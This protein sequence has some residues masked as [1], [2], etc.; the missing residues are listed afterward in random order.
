MY[1]IIPS[2]KSI[3]GVRYMNHI[4]YTMKSVFFYGLR[5]QHL[6]L[7]RFDSVVI[8]LFHGDAQILVSKAVSLLG[9]TAHLFHDPAAQGYTVGITFHIKL[10]AEK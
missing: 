7:C 4:F 3:G 5:F 8:Q 9:D 2:D 6:D 1:T 10:I